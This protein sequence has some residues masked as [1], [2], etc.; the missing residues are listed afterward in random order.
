M[1]SSAN[2]KPDNQPQSH[3]P[4]CAD[5]NCESCNALRKTYEQ[6]RLGQAI[7]IRKSG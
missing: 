7:P 1:A 5:P 2:P 6:I 4:Y 3:P